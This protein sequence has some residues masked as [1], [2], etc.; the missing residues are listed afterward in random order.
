MNTETK[1]VSIDDILDQTLDDLADLPEWKPF[2]AGAH[3]VV[4]TAETGKSSNGKPQ[5]KVKL[6]A[7]ET[8]ELANKGDEMLEKGAE[9]QVLYTLDNEYGQGSFKKLMAAFKEHL[10]L[11][12][13][14]KN[15]EILKASQGMEIVVITTVRENKDKTQKFTQIQEVAFD[16]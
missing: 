7:V 9:V 6:V 4:F 2:P 15:G 1:E 10:Q 11:P 12:D 3:K 16:A 5:V 8:V 14:V 13:G